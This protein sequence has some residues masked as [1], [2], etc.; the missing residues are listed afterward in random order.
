VTSKTEHWLPPAEE[1]DQT[2]SEGEEVRRP[3]TWLIVDR[4]C[5]HSHSD[6]H[7]DRVG[8]QPVD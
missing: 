5:E 6:G 4:A 8:E 7:R 1:Q 3:G 2:K